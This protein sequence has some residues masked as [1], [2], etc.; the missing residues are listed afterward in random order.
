MWF[1]GSGLLCVAYIALFLPIRTRNWP[2]R[3]ISIKL[4]GYL[5]SVFKIILKEQFSQNQLSMRL[6][7]TRSTLEIHFLPSSRKEKYRYNMNVSYIPVWCNSLTTIAYLL[8]W[9]CW[10]HFKS[11]SAQW[12]KAGLTK[13]LT[14]HIYFSC[15]VKNHSALTYGRMVTCHMV[16]SFAVACQSSS[17][18]I[19][20][21]CGMPTESNTASDVT[22][23]EEAS[24]SIN[25]RMQN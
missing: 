15:K 25:H 8:W 17:N 16:W 20:E 6:T 3:M 10:W 18:P 14:P 22:L 4:M 1:F 9:Q 11:P 23:I 24:F 5:F 21:S 7:S 12:L 19:E 13:Q 2:L